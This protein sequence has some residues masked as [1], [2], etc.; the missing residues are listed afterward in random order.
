[1]TV[2]RLMGIMA[3]FDFLT[4]NAVVVGYAL[5]LRVTGV[6]AALSYYYV[7]HSLVLAMMFVFVA[8]YFGLYRD[9]WYFQV[10]DDLGRIF[11]AVTMGTLI[12]F[13]YTFIFGF[14]VKFI[15]VIFLYGI[16][17]VGFILG[18]IAFGLL[19][20]ALARLGIGAR[21]LLV[22]GTGLPARTF[23]DRVRRDA[24]IGYKLIGFVSPPGKNDIAVNK[25]LVL[26]SFDDLRN[27]VV[28]NDIDELVVTQA[29]DPADCIRDIIDVCTGLDITIRALPDLYDIVSAKV[30]MSRVE[31]VP[32]VEVLSQPLYGWYHLV[33]RVGDIIF[34]MTGLLLGIP[35]WI[36]LAF[37]VPRQ[38][39][40]SLIYRQERI[41]RDGKQ[42]DMLKFRSMVVDAEESTGPT[43][44]VDDDPRITPIGRFIRR[45]RIDEIPQMINV[46]KNQM[47]VIGPRPERPSFVEDFSELIP[48]YKRRL[49]VKPGITGL[50][51][52]KHKYDETLDDVKEKLKYDLFYIDNQSLPLDLKILLLTIIVLLTGKG[53]K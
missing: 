6:F 33:K 31:G 34:A 3:A 23:A 50:A 44:T 7:I 46:L 26:G 17:Y 42:F 22:L 53:V 8:A 11:K 21:R 32:L 9:R 27:V 18:R 39:G 5:I 40:G 20:R 25:D 36:V 10:S 12:L 37:I 52:V 14:T 29:H 1:M 28:E 30:T 2:K 13:A 49:I 24:Q 47:S 4:V 15:Y 45:F 38:S 48:F 41:G 35:I 16:L 51:Q 43:W 19:I